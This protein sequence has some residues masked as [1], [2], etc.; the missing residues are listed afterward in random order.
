MNKMRMRD[1]FSPDP[2]Q[3]RLLAF[4]YALLGLIVCFFGRGIIIWA[5]RLIGVFAVLYGAFQLYIYFGRGN[6]NSSSPLMIGLPCLIVGLILWIWPAALVNVFPIVIGIFLVFNSLVGIQKAF[7]LKDAG[8][9]NWVISL[10]G[11][12]VML[13]GGIFLIAFP[14]RSVRYMFRVCGIFLIAEALL[15][16]FNSFEQQKYL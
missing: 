13:A 6:R 10:V 14:D 7:I 9:T 12:L 1:F 5:V 4:V 11:A 2:N 16:L 8:F 15:L 3:T